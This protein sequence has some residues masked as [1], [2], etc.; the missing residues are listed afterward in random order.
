MRLDFGKKNNIIWCCLKMLLCMKLS[1]F[2]ISVPRISIMLTIT[3]IKEI[4]HLPPSFPVN[5]FL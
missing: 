5:I 2:S 3:K 4:H 1:K